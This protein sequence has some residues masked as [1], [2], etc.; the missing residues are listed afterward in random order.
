MYYLLFLHNIRI[1]LYKI[2]NNVIKIFLTEL[3]AR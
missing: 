2:I 1:L 3:N